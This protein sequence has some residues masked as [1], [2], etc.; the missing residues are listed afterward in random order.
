MLKSVRVALDGYEHKREQVFN[1]TLGELGNLIGDTKRL[2]VQCLSRLRCRQSFVERLRV[3]RGRGSDEQ[4]CD[5]EKS[6]GLCP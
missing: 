1:L 4:Q 6:H 2:L 3:L 5:R